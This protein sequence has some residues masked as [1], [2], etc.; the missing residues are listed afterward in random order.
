MKV[1]G[2]WVYK[3]LGFLP[4]MESEKVLPEGASRALAVL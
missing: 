1:L 4:G 3:S 2:F